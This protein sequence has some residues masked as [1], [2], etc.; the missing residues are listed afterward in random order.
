MSAAATN[1]A[2]S[3][4]GYSVRQATTAE[5]WAVAA[6]HW[7]AGCGAAEAIRAVESGHHAVVEGYCTDCPGFAGPVVVAVGAAGAGLLQRL[8]RER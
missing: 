2:W 8:H 1:A 7:D 6:A 4:E 3:A 5:Q